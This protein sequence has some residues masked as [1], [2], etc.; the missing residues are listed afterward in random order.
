MKVKF[1]NKKLYIK[2]KNW[3]SRYYWA[4]RWPWILGATSL[5]FIFLLRQGSQVYHIPKE[6]K[7]VKF[8]SRLSLKKKDQIAMSLNIIITMLIILYPCYT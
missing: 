7:H 1:K 3:V 6:F 2:I 8:K 5:S 4:V